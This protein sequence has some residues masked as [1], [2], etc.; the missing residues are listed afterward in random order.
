MFLSE[1]KRSLS[2]YFGVLCPV[3]NTHS[4]YLHA[5]HAQGAPFKLVFSKCQ[6]FFLHSTVDY[7]MATHLPIICKCF[8]NT[9]F[10][11]SSSCI[12]SKLKPF[13]EKLYGKRKKFNNLPSCLQAMSM[14]LILKSEKSDKVCL[15]STFLITSFPLTF[16]FTHN[17]API[18]QSKQ[19]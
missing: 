2:N 7:E 16:K 4:S 15:F 10:G 14:W 18:I 19:D 8:V 17:Y 13:I 12:Q 11:V 9:Y 6:P 5:R 3:C 1:S